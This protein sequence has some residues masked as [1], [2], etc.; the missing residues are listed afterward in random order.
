MDIPAFERVRGLADGRASMGPRPLLTM[1]PGPRMP[2][3]AHRL[4]WL[5]V[6][7]GRM[8]VTEEHRT[9]RKVPIQ[10]RMASFFSKMLVDDF[11]TG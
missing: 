7:I 11:M 8:S 6:V 1:H 9:N 5:W 2:S 3:T 10:I 4:Q